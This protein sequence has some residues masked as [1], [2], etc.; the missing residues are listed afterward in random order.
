MR[1]MLRRLRGAVGMGLTWA[2][3]WFGVGLVVGLVGLQV[4]AAAFGSGLA[5]LAYNSLVSAGAG[6]IGG[7]VFSAV[8]RVAEGR[9]RFDEMSMLRFAIWGGLG[10]LVVAGLQVGLFMLVM[11]GTPSFLYYF[12]IQGLM[13]AGSATGTLVLA[14]KADDPA[15]LRDGS[16]VDDVGLTAEEKR[17]L[18]GS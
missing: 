9:R 2:V 4:G 16:D 17:Q 18:L 10:G 8:L 13:G 5:W 7:T 14:R 15:G 12:G 6:F 11:G 1:K 3:A